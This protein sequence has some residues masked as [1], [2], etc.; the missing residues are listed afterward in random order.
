M[1]SAPK[2]S[3]P[4]RFSSVLIILWKSST[5]ASAWHRFSHGSSS[6]STR[7]IGPAGSPAISVGSRLMSCS[8]SVM[9]RSSRY[10]LDFHRNYADHCVAG[11]ERGEFGLIEVL[12][13]FRPLGQHE[14]TD[15]GR[16]IV[17]ADLDIVR[18]SR[19]ELS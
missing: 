2:A 11:H 12:S 1:I 15:H 17:D 3:T 16:G 9:S 7:S 14:I 13:P 18:N 19:P 10:A 6:C 8:F 5:S 4:R